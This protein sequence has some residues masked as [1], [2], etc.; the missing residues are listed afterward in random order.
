MFIERLRTPKKGLR[1]DSEISSRES[2]L[3]NPK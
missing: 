2:N 3:G 1:E